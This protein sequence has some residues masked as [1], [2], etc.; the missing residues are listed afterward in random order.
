MAPGNDGVPEQVAQQLG[1]VATP[2]TSQISEYVRR[3]FQDSSGHLWFGS[4][5]DGVCRYDGTHLTY[6]S[7]N[8]G[9]AGTQVLGIMEDRKGNMWFATRGGVSRYDGRSIT[10]YTS[11]DGLGADGAAC[12]LMDRNGVIWA[13]NSAGACR[14]NGSTFTAFPIPVFDVLKPDSATELK[15]VAAM[16]QDAQ[17]NMW[18]GSRGEG[19]CKYDGKT[20]TRFTTADG[21]CDNEVVCIVQDKQGNMWISTMNGGVSRYDG[22]GFTNY[23]TANGAIG[24]DEVWTMR[25]DSRGDVWF[26]SEGYGVYR[27]N[28]RTFSN[29]AK[30]EGLGVGAVQTVM[31]DTKGRIWVG[32]GGGLYRLEGGAFINVRRN[33]PWPAL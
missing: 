32:G 28:G 13:G 4:N 9:L 22:H 3:I 17:G 6:F 24:N 25:V 5:T 14:F 21:L 19:V 27:Y 33:G 18:F 16:L 26:S 1:R 11:K 7:T 30:K 10:T 31:E 23:S 8:E 2:D 12:L 15:H 20:F 29:Y